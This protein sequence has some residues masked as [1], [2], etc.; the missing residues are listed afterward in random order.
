MTLTPYRG[1][2]HTCGHDHNDWPNVVN[3]LE[4]IGRLTKQRDE[5]FGLL[6]R[7]IKCESCHHK[8]RKNLFSRP[9]CA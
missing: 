2:C 8:I 4:E 6:T 3:P 7:I 5:L 1:R 9:R